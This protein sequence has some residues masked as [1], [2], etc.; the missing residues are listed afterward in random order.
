MMNEF[1]RHNY[2][3]LTYAVELL[4]V[5]TGLFCYK[6]YKHNAATYFI[7]FLIYTFL[8]DALGGYNVYIKKFN[9]FYLIEDTILERNFLWY[10]IFWSMGS[11]LFYSFFYRRILKRESFKSLLKYATFMALAISI[12]QIIVHFNTLYNGFIPTVSIVTSLVIFLA[13]T[14]YFIDILK[15]DKILY[16]YNSIYFYIST[17]LLIWWLITT[18]M[19]FYQIYFS[20]ADWNFVLLKWQIYLFAN[21]FMYLT[22]TFALIFCKPEK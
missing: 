4:A 9:A 2:T 20:T 16:F 19:V 7:V 8:I 10:T 22:F 21:L 3:L 14:L 13:I 6:K 12:F 5:I 18:P 15:T 17:V 11:M 1:L